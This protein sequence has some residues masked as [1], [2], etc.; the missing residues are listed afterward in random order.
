MIKNRL[1]R[2]MNDMIESIKNFFDI[3]I[4]LVAFIA[5]I[6]AIFL[7]MYIIDN[8]ANKDK[9]QSTPQDDKDLDV[10]EDIKTAISAANNSDY[11]YPYQKVYLLT[12]NEWAFYRKLKPITDKY[13]LHILSKVRMADIVQVKKGL[14]NKQYYSAFGKIKSRHIDF[15]LADP[16]NLRILAAIEL[17]D[18]SHQNVDR[19]QADFFEN[20]LFETIGLPLIRTNG[21]DDIEKELCEK[22]KISVKQ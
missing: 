9:K 3:S 16:R 10:Q 22:L 7:P 6:C 19:Q 11:E 1:E 14:T 2:T 20:K 17:D 4:S 13:R 18:N 12:K 15:V 8:L 21:K 5:V